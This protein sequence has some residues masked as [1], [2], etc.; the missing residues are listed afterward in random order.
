LGMPHRRTREA[1]LLGLAAT[2]ALSANYRAFVGVFAHTPLLVLQSYLLFAGLGVMAMLWRATRAPGAVISAYGCGGNRP[3]HG[4]IQ[5]KSKSGLMLAQWKQWART[6]KRNAHALY[7]AARDPRVPW[8][9]KGLAVVVAAYAASPI[10]L[11]P[12][13]VP[14]IDPG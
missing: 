3:A 1:W 11:I 8:Y 12:D 10:D 4:R 7:L 6:T 9:A 5:S 2:F 14:V 13:F